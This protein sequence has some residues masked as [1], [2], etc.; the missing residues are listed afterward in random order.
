MPDASGPPETVTVQVAVVNDRSVWDDVTQR[1]ERSMFDEG[2]CGM[3][4][5][6]A[7]LLVVLG[8]ALGSVLTT[9]LNPIGAA[10]ALVGASSPSSG[11]HVSILQQ[12]LDTLVGKGTITKSQADAVKNQVHS[13]EQQHPHPFAGPMGRGFHLPGALGGDLQQVFAQLKT[14]PQA[15]FSELRAG[16][17]IAQIAQEKGVDVAKLEQDMVTAADQGIDQAVKN[18][19][20]TSAQGA[21]LKAKVPTQVHDLLNRK[22]NQGFGMMPGFMGHGH[23]LGPS[24]APAAP[25]TTAPKGST[26]TAPPKGS[27]TT[28]P[29]KGSTTTSEGSTTTT[30]H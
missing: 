12:A 17:T 15:L 16:K 21:T 6:P 5:G 19:W 2:K 9:V 27:T 1:G 22:W 4:K 26:T 10:S 11:A 30:T 23:G 18:G 8:M 28:A 7:A 24:T 14:D 13:L 25:G 20:M 29:P 3:K